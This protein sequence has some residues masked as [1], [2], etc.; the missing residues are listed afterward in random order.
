MSRPYNHDLLLSFRT[1][2][3]VHNLEVRSD[4]PPL[5]RIASKFCLTRA[6]SRS[7]E[8]TS[9]TTTTPFLVTYLLLATAR[10]VYQN[11]THLCGSTIRIERR[12][13]IA[14]ATL[15]CATS[16]R[17][18]RSRLYSRS[19][20]SNPATRQIRHADSPITVVKAGC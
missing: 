8:T 1:Y 9:K 18:H 14:R 3:S 5:H 17:R 10:E 19:H 13:R 11:P 4:C 6:Y 2:D 16:S 7:A 15:D 20:R 12:W